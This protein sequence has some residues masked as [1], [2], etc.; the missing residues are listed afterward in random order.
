MRTSRYR[1]PWMSVARC[2]DN[3]R[4]RANT[5]GE[6]AGQSITISKASSSLRSHWSRDHGESAC[7]IN[8]VGFVQRAR[9]GKG[10]TRSPRMPSV[11]AATLVKKWTEPRGNSIEGQTGNLATVV[12]AFPMLRVL[13]DRLYVS[14]RRGGG[15]AYMKAFNPR[16]PWSM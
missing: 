6:G 1:F 13:A 4:A 8:S 5:F 11:A 9:Q 12:D 15:F 3:Y 16:M 2:N 7:V 10:S 14:S